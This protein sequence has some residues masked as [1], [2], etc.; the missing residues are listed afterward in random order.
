M[1]IPTTPA[2]QLDFSG[3]RSLPE[4]FKDSDCDVF[5]SN[6]TLIAVKLCVSRLPGDTLQTGVFICES[7]VANGT[8]VTTSP[9]QNITTTVSFFE[10]TATMLSS[11]SN[12]TIVE[13]S[14][15]SEP[16]KMALSDDDVRGY[17]VALSWLLDYAK[18]GIPAPSSIIES[19][20][21]SRALLGDSTIDGILLQNLQSILAFPV[22]L[23]NANNWGNTGVQGAGLSPF[24]P[25]EF[26][27]TAS[28]VKP[29]VKLE[30]DPVVLVLFIVFQGSVLL[31]LWGLLAWTVLA[32]GGLPAVSSFPL[33]DFSFKS[34]V[35]MQEASR[36]K[37]WNAGD[38][39]VLELVEGAKVVAWR[40]V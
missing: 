40:P 9:P 27:K 3:R 35:D 21:T 12:L 25:S 4:S 37:V 38:S 7:V 20:W 2:I 29:Y 16:K 28:I 13:I 18:A 11:R 22:W 8:C 19:F 32:V 39:E 30:F 5:S 17:R 36:E 1:R 14:N 24:V 33:F 10:R 34:G 31:F 15:L 23:F 6:D 26:Y